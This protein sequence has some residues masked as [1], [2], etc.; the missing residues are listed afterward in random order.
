MRVDFNVPIKDGVVADP[1][2][3]KAAIPSIK[4]I[5]DAGAKALVL[6]SHLGRPDGKKTDKESLRPIVPILESLS[7][8]T[9][10]FI[11]DCVGPAT[12]ALCANPTPGSLILL[13]N[14]R[15]HLEEEV[16]VTV[17]GQKV[18][19]N[20]VDV[21]NFKRSLSSL[22]DVY[23]N[24]AFGTAHRAHSSMTGILHTTR[25]AGFLMGKELEAF[26][27]IMENPKRPLIVMMGG[28][29]VADKIKI[30]MKMLDVV[31]EMIF[32]GAIANTFKKTNEGMKIGTSLFDAAGAA[33]IP[34]IIKKAAEKKVKLH[35]PSDFVAEKDGEV[36]TFSDKT[37]IDYGWNAKDVGPETIERYAKILGTA[38]TILWNGPFGKFEDPKF[39]KGSIGIAKILVELSKKGIATIVGGGETA[40]LVDS[41]EGASEAITHISTGGGASLELLEGKV[42][43][44]VAD[45]S[46]K[47][48]VERRIANKH[49]R[50]GINGFGRIGRLVCR[51]AF[52][53]KK[54][55]VVAINEP[56]MDL[57]YMVYQFKYDSMHG[58]WH[59]EV[60]K[61][62]DMLVING[63][64]IKVYKELDA[65]NVPWGKNVLDYL[66][67]CS[68][69]FLTA[70]ACQ[71]HL[72]MG[73]KKVIMSAPPKDSTPL[74]CMGVNHLEYKPELKVISNASCTTN[75]LAPMAKIIHEKF[76]IIEGLMTTVHS[77]TATQL[78]NDGPSKG[79]KD[80]RAGRAA[81]TN[82]IP[83]TTGAARAVGE[84]LPSLKGKLT[85]MAFRVPTLNVSVV[86]LT[87]RTAK[88]AKMEQIVDEM[89][90]AASG[91]YKGIVDVTEDEVVSS[92]FNH[93]P[94]SCVFDVKASIA[95]NPCFLKLVAWYDN[96]WGYS[97]RMID[98]IYHMA[99]V[100]GFLH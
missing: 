32:G 37:G 52:E 78:T 54:V 17:E 10:K 33:Q 34:D 90:K 84:V 43:P 48:P 80:W 13:E 97:N 40:Q 99:T 1:A 96:E 21:A 19:A 76:E 12:E 100:D 61:L 39:S 69:V 46:W 9:V 36:R 14:L 50:I 91:P 55:E 20:K 85:G 53:S 44:G 58:P 62:H 15:F 47:T 73:A 88:A 71:A 94:H 24:D 56:F 89:K 93:N 49:A 26:A 6:M 5:F 98:L 29:K 75:C 64:A 59:G 67:E 45:L 70:E 74:F 3:I 8:R 22:G 23:V 51:A 27:K 60:T 30:I 68:G 95:L 42:L 63:V 41:V 16:S 66:A 38:N 7:G 25:A 2:R 11:E 86:D 57:D 82:L 28:A 92:D 18:T 81:S 83:S 31:D 77:T 4:A 87:I 35:F 72:A 79:G 65:Y